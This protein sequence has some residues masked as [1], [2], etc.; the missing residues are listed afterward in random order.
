MPLGRQSFFFF[1][2]KLKFAQP[3]V[4]FAHIFFFFPAGSVFCLVHATWVR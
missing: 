1:L 4:L 3:E 2:R